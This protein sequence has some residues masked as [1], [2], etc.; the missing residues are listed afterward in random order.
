M[1]GFP[2]RRARDPEGAEEVRLELLP[3][4]RL[5]DL[6]DRPEEAMAGVVDDDVETPEAVGR[7]GQRRI[8]GGR[9]GHVERQRE[10]PLTAVP[11]GQVMEALEP[12]S[13]RE[14]AVSS[15]APP[16]PRRG[17]SRGTSR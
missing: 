11:R 6:L 15:R 3:D 8:D 17:R 7:G 14:D 13:G 16:R 9:V 12:A 5:G 1:S 4:L 2:D 10:Q